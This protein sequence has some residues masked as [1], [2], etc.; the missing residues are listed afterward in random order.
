M[1]KWRKKGLIKDKDGKG[2][3]KQDALNMYNAL[4]KIHQEKGLATNYTRMQAGQE[5]NY[6]AEDLKAM[7][8]AAGYEINADALPQ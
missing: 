2:L 7:A 8:E 6:S 4:N 1:K 3:T 5:F